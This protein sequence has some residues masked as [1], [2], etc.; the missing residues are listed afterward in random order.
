SQ[1]FDCGVNDLP[2]EIVLSWF[3]Q[4]A[5]AVLLTLLALDVK[6]IRVGPVPPAFI[7][8]NVFKV[9]Q[10]KFDLKIIEAEPPVEL[11]QLAT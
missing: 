11:V 7:T 10:D 1:A 5:V 4:K 3:E 9:L 8:P 6:G 2:L